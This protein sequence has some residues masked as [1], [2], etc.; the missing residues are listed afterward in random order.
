MR[1]MFTGAAPW[2]NSGYSKPLRYLFPRL[3]AAGHEIAL[4]AFYG[5]DGTTTET[6]VGGAR[7]R[8]YPTARDG[9]FNDIIEYH[10]ASWQAQAVITLQD[11]WILKDWGKKPFKW[12]PGC[13]STRTRL[14]SRSC[15]PS[16]AATPRWCGWT[17]PSTSYSR[18]GGC[19]RA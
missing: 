11:V 2:A 10:A 8:I 13:P 17:G 19:R 3:A 18:P 1:L 9:Y 12:C 4:C 14:A 15:R 6:D 16:K 7:V 5:W